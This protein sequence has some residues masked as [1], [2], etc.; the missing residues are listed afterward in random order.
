[1]EEIKLIETIPIEPLPLDSP[2][3]FLYFS[4]IPVA[5]GNI[6]QIN[7]KEKKTYGYVYKVRD[8]KET[9]Q[10]L[11]KLNFS[12]KPL[13]EIIINKKVLTPI[14]EKLAFWLAKNYCLSLPHAF[15]FFLKFF[16]KMTVV[17]DAQ[18]EIGTRFI[19]KIKKSLATTDLKKLPLLV[20]TPLEDHAFLVYEKLKREFVEPEKVILIDLEE[21]RKVFNKIIEAILKKERFLFVG[22][23]N[24]LFLPWLKLNQ[25]IVIEEGDIFY[26][27]YFKSP[28]FNY[29]NIIEKLAKFLKTELLLISDLPSFKTIVSSKTYQQDFSSF[30]IENIENFGSIFELERIIR[31]YKK[32]KIFS[33]LKILSKKLRCQI[34]FY[35]FLCSK[36]NFPLSIY[37]NNAYCRVCFRKYS[38]ENKCPHCGSN[39][40]YVGGVGAG[41][42]KRYL[43]K[44]GYYVWFIEDKEA[45]KK[46]LKKIPERYILLGSYSL[47]NP[48]LPFVDASIFINFDQIFYTLNPFLK[49]K[50]LRIA[51][52]LAKNSSILYLHCRQEEIIKKILNGSIVEEILEERKRG[53][54]PPY[55]RLIKIISR[56]KNL[57][58]LNQRLIELRNLIEKNFLKNELEV[59]GPF[60]ERIPLKKRRYQMFLLLRLYK[61]INLKNIL[62]DIPYIEEI[63]ADEEDI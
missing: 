39:D 13:N 3:F 15:Y 9:K 14:Q 51:L 47:L 20:L 10:M 26:K 53:K 48:Y 46:F 2:D 57:E 11:K 5:K 23:K 61:E 27:E 56:L 17:N 22:S 29:L 50:Y 6:I 43:E 54:L 24:C 52:N 1:M 44:M 8:L 33:P 16:K 40:I 36:C 60:L 21:K 7:L 25:I 58:K 28:Y 31:N 45:V 41:W 30:K 35:E 42:I 34:C 59:S 18:E 63:R 37:E 32:V 38:L 4:T 55:S 12:I 49:E 62:K 19:K